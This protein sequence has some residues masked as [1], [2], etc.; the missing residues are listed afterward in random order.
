MPA[1]S[2]KT[3][4]AAAKLADR[5]E[6]LRFL[7]LLALAAAVLRAFVF[8]PFSIPTGSMLPGMM[9]GDYLFVTK[10]NYGYSRYSL[11][12]H[13]PLIPGRVLARL[14]DRGDVVVFKYPGAS[15]VDYVKRVIGLPGDR[16][17]VRDGVVSIN[18]AAV[19]RDRIADWPMPVSPNSPCRRQGEDVRDLGDTCIHPRYRETLPGGRTIE[20]LDS[21]AGPL[22][23]TPVFVVPAD[24][25][26]MLGDNRDDSLDSRVPVDRLGVGLV[27]V[28]HLVGRAGIAFFSTDGSA[29]LL[30]PWTWLTAARFGRIGTIY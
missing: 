2:R 16:I 13:L 29:E 15:K 19:P 9:V 5:W 26:F 3:R 20:V 10:W 7:V 14:P 25:L 17:R 22:D 23:D 18:G 8:A 6:L 11:P 12:F 28:D 4:R 24:H 30:K 21:G 27:P 1:A